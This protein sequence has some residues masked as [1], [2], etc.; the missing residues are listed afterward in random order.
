MGPL[1]VVPDLEAEVD[2][3]YRLPLEEFTSARNDLAQRLKRAGQ[4]DAAADVQDLRKPTVPVWAINQLAHEY[5]KDV[6]ALIE[7]S[8]QLRAAQER[9]LGGGD[10]DQLRSAASAEREAL[11]KLT[12][13]AQELL[14]R[15]AP[16]ATLERVASTLRVAALAPETRELLRSG[17]LS[18]ELKSAGFGAFEGMSVPAR[19]RPRP[20]KKTAARPSAA[21]RRRDERLAKLRDRLTKLRQEAADAEREAKHAQTAADRARARLERAAAA[22]EK[23]QAELEAA[24]DVSGATRP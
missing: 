18:E 8:D 15:D 6:E 23:A 3:L 19:P 17:R 13:S 5:G 10:S 12:D 2:R 20:R 22:V 24:E 4:K 14:G 7:A 11:R 21:E 9:A 16:A 1:A